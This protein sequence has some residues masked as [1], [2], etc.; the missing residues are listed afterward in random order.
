MLRAR[1]DVEPRWLAT[2]ALVAAALLGLPGCRHSVEEEP[3][4]PERVEQDC[5]T[6]EGCQQLLARLGGKRDFCYREYGTSPER[7]IDCDW[8]DLYWWALKDHIELTELRAQRQNAGG[9]RAD[10]QRQVEIRSL[11][12][13][14]QQLD[15]AR[16][17]WQAERDK[18][19]QVDRTWREVD[20]RKCAIEGDEDAC[21]RLVQFIAL[22]DSPQAAEAKAAL[23]AGQKVI[24]ERKKRSAK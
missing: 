16:Q 9:E 15:Q 6:R 20:P 24:A 12:R 13:E 10:R 8:N 22:G 17:D 19:A 3:S 21:Y 18:A 23:A 7:P 2:A 14:R 4:F 1:H 5:R 11:S